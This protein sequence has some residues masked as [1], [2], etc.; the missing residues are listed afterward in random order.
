MRKF[1]SLFLMACMSVGAFA[2][3]AKID[4]IYYNLGGKNATVTYRDQNYN[5]YSGEV[6]VPATVEYNGTEYTVTSIGSEA[7]RGCSSLTTITLPNSVTSINNQAFS[8]CSSLT[9]ITLP[10]SITS[11]DSYAFSGCSSLTTIT[12]PNSI[13]SIGSEAFTSPVLSVTVL[14]N[15]P[16]SLGTNAFHENTIFFVPDVNT[17]KDAWKGY[18]FIVPLNGVSASVNIKALADKSALQQKLGLDSL[19]KITSLKV[20][21]TI[22]SYDIMMMRNQ[23]PNLWEIDLSDA[24]IV[25]NDYEY[26]K[27]YHSNPYCIFVYR[28]GYAYSQSHIA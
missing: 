4:G 21:G 24:S 2:Y 16:A 10:N 6:V 14:G 8:G 17:Y 1:L 7:F 9:A 25:A 22:N 26:T 19:K 11:I 28:Y 5:S 20:S 15:K 23:M 12:L 3:S 18:K 13:T 27:G